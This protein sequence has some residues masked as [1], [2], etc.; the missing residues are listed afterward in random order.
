MASNLSVFN[1]LKIITEL[2]LN[3]HQTPEDLHSS[4]G[5]SREVEK[6]SFQENS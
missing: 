2:K 6:Y 4:L 1:V 3:P 5:I